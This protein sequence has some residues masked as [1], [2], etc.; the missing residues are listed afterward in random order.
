[1]PAA[2]EFQE[3]GGG[4]FFWQVY[5]PAVKTDVTC[6][7]F[8]AG[9]EWFFVDPIPLAASALDELASEDAGGGAILL[10]NANHERRPR[11]IAI[12]SACRSWRMPTPRPKS[13]LHSIG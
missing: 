5:D 2:D 10:T 4:R 12:A 11:P 8:R 6:T 9:R 1:M 13:R 3:L 7:A